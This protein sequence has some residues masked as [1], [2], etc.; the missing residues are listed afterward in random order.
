[1]RRCGRGRRP[2]SPR[3]KT[4]QR[5]PER[6]ESCVLL[7]SFVRSCAQLECRGGNNV[8]GPIDY[9]RGEK[10]HHHEPRHFDDVCL[11]RDRLVVLGCTLLQPKENCRPEKVERNGPGHFRVVPH[12]RRT[13]THCQSPCGSRDCSGKQAADSDS[14]GHRTSGE[15]QLLFHV[16][17]LARPF[18]QY[19]STKYLRGHFSDY[20]IS[21]PE[22]FSSEVA[23]PSQY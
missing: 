17:A 14:A 21:W 8:L 5:K 6:R 11:Y 20:N 1:M 4:A 10:H 18:A 12:R 7:V 22:T 23:K 9:D 15:R 16:W 2:H 13:R 19:F 3:L